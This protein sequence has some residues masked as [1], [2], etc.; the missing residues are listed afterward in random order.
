MKRQWVIIASALIVV[1]L[2]GLMFSKFNISDNKN[3]GFQHEWEFSNMSLD[4]INI[5]SDS[6][7]I[8][9]QFVESKDDRIYINA[10]GK[11]S[12]DLV[13]KL[14]SATITNG[15]F[16]LD[17]TDNKTIEFMSFGYVED[18][19]MLTVALP[20]T[21]ELKQLSAKMS[22]GDLTLSNLVTDNVDLTVT[23]GDIQVTNSQIT[24]LVATSNS[25]EVDIEEH[26]G[27]IDIITTSGDMDINQLAGNSNLQTHSGD[28]ELTQHEQSQA[29]IKGKSGDVEVTQLKESYLDINVISGDVDVEIAKDFSGVLSLNS[30]SGSIKS[31]PMKSNYV[32]SEYFV[33]IK[34]TSGDI[35]V[36][37]Q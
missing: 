22:S 37:Q 11:V 26:K 8:S 36:N 23:S 6:T 31:P 29:T 1:G 5:L 19:V 28:I 3:Q 21:N 27:D 12:R 30:N 34:S 13:D 2:I 20:K 14:K 4:H 15:E 17:F 10:K 35:E 32:L 25:G 9:L 18:D 33:R 16:L 24:H 7:D